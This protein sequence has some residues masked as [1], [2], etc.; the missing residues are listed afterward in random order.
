MQMWSQVLLEN[1]AA[2]NS[3]DE[4]G[5]TPLHGASKD[6]HEAVMKVG[7]SWCVCGVTGA[8]AAGMGHG[9]MQPMLVMTVAVQ[10]SLMHA[11]LAVVAL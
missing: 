8:G 5:S 10:V 2:V 7:V 11:T 9:T 3:T 6:G 4:Y 1:G